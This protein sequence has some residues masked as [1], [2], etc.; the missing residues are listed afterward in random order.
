[1]VAGR[2][3]QSTASQQHR[4]GCA[5]ERQLAVAPAFSELPGRLVELATFDQRLD[6]PGVRTESAIS[7]RLRSL[8]RGRP[9]RR[10]C[11]ESRDF[12]PSAPAGRGFCWP[13]TDLARTRWRTRA[14]AVDL[15]SRLGAR[16]RHRWIRRVQRNAHCRVELGVGQ[17]IACE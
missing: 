7:A 9:Q 12:R 13:T 11:Q 15:S 5:G 1:V 10:L 6:E 3:V 8:R 16:E 2:G 4:C 17:R 14:R